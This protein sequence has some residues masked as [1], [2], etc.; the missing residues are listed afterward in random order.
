MTFGFPII[1]ICSGWDYSKFSTFD[2]TQYAFDDSC[3][4]V[5]VKEIVNKHGH[6]SVLIDNGICDAAKNL[7]CSRSIIIHYNSV[8][9]VLNSQIH[10]GVRTN[11]VIWRRFSKCVTTYHN[12][13]TFTL[14]AQSYLNLYLNHAAAAPEHILLGGWG[15]RTHTI[16]E[17]FFG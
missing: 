3:T 5:L 4:Y 15:G 2:G 8:E 7:S 9:I 17:I 14:T 11:K 1:G 12:Q 10:E 6:F 13:F 16:P